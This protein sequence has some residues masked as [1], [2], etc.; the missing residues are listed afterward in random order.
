MMRRQIHSVIVLSYSCR[1][2]VRGR[3]GN[4]RVAIPPTA[5]HYGGG[6][7]A[8]GSRMTILKPDAWTPMAAV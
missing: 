3:S 7:S 4:R 2:D 1:T 8:T 5:I 6:R